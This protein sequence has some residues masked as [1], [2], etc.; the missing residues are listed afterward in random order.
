MTTANRANTCACKSFDAERCYAIRYNLDDDEIE[1]HA[2]V[3]E[4]SCHDK[5]ED[6]YEDAR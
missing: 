1:D 2:E 5:D 3:C 6:D 4:C